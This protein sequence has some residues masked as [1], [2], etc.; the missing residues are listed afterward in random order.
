MN[1]MSVWLWLR[2]ALPLLGLG[3]F[4]CGQ[5]ATPSDAAQVATSQEALVRS[6]QVWLPACGS[7]RCSNLKTGQNWFDTN[8]RERVWLAD[9]TG[10][11]AQ[12]A[13][14]DL[15]A[16]APSG[17]VTVATGSGTNFGTPLLKIAGSAFN[18]GYFSTTYRQRVW[19]TDVTGDGRADIVGIANDGTIKVQRSTGTGFAGLTSSPSPFAPEDGWFDPPGS[20]NPDSSQRVWLIDVNGDN[21]KDFIGIGFAGDI[22]VSLANG[23]GFDAATGPVWS[24]FESADG[25]FSGA[26]RDRVW[27]ADYIGSSEPDIL[28]M[29]FNGDVYI[30]EGKPGGGYWPTRLVANSG[31]DSTQTSTGTNWFDINYQSRI[32]ATEDVSGDG[33]ADIVGVAPPGKGD[34]DVWVLRS[35]PGGFSQKVWLYDS[36]FKTSQA[37]NNWFSTAANPRLW[38]TD[39]T[40]D[41]RADLVGVN[42][43]GQVWAAKADSAAST[44]GSTTKS[45]YFQPS[46]LVA[47]SSIGDYFDPQFRSRVWPADVTGDGV[48]DLVAIAPS[49]VTQ[50]DGT[51]T[52]TQV[53]PTR[54]TS[55]TS[56]GRSQL[57][58]LPTILQARFSRR[59]NCTTMS[60]G[61]LSVYQK[62]EPNAETLLTATAATQ[63]SSPSFTCNFKRTFT[64]AS[65]D[66]KIRRELDGLAVRD[67]WNQEVD[68]NGNGFRD[69]NADRSLRA[70]YLYAGL[71]AGA[72]K[73]IV[74]RPQDNEASRGF[75][76]PCRDTPEPMARAIV[77]GNADKTVAFVELELIG[78]NPGRLRELITAR[79][80][81]PGE[82]I[83]ISATHAHSL[84]WTLNLYTA[85]GY[86][87]RTFDGRP[88]S[89][90]APIFYNYD[91][92][93]LYPWLQWIEDQAAEQVAAAYAS[94]VP[95]QIGAGSM[96]YPSSKTIRP[97]GRNRWYRAQQNSRLCD[98]EHGV[99]KLD[100]TLGV[101][102]LK[103]MTGAP[104]A[105]LMNYAEH[106]VLQKRCTSG[107]FPSFASDYVET[108][109]GYP[110]GMYINGAG[111]DINPQPGDLDDPHPEV[112]TDPAVPHE[113]GQDLGAAAMIKV[114]E[115]NFFGSSQGMH[116]A[117]VRD[118]HE[119]MGPSSCPG[120]CI[121]SD[122][123]FE[124]AHGTP[125]S[126]ELESTSLVVTNVNQQRV[127]AVASVP[128]ELFIQ[129]QIDLKAALGQNAFVFG[130]TNGYYG[131]FPD[132]QASQCAQDL[133]IEGDPNSCRL[134]E[135]PVCGTDP[136]PRGAN[137]PLCYQAYVCADA[138]GGR[139][140]TAVFTDV[141]AD[142]VIAGDRMIA[143]AISRI[144][145]MAP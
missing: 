84:P 30:S 49:G 111:G 107:D 14:A 99:E 40:G 9:V 143:N 139:F 3:A 127:F 136:P 6:S 20:A 102:A 60:P 92:G 10:L 95:V 129:G 41:G 83:L 86:D 100:P 13:V 59:M 105:L 54:V 118:V 69:N 97:A 123:G 25:W 121:S 82:N 58:G 22:W 68:G 4:G 19:V 66:V 27:V 85:A 98:S 114:S 140:Q 26:F 5:V 42:W 48:K 17:D 120:Y 44:S 43:A 132:A 81:I 96:Q 141:P 65:G 63:P 144:Q 53:F 74:P 80:G 75:G 45:F 128:G 112:P 119:F 113:Y 137:E 117:S 29:A 11:D 77:L 50:P 108:V 56:V 91:G 138:G 104:L 130:Y 78:V 135:S 67:R 87:E 62:I 7:G 70:D 71:T 55:T 145:Q 18:S 35:I 34:G 106:P 142:G 76:A 21:K 122:P 90:P 47:S 125:N 33:K 38:L 2:R 110:V 73:G 36:K 16:I 12:G 61:A 116:I 15:V 89:Q 28:G 57:N 64:S 24:S 23:T 39:V 31:F 8:S 72:S 101:I 79:T 88:F 37:D 126:L 51:V 103:T 133:S 1:N 115:P 52:W 32:W 134:I 124:R 46:L 109:G 94:M 131:Y 93:G